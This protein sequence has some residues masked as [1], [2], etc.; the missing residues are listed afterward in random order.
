MLTHSSATGKRGLF[1]KTSARVVLP[2]TQEDPAG[3]DP[4]SPFEP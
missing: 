2:P 3:P 4:R 1:K